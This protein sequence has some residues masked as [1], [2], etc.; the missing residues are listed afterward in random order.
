[1]PIKHLALLCASALALFTPATTAYRITGSGECE[2]P[3]GE[4]I[5]LSA[6][7][8]NDIIYFNNHCKE[9]MTVYYYD[10]R[11]D[12]K[13]EAFTVNG[14]TDGSDDTGGNAVYGLTAEAA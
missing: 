13:L 9:D 10:M 14:Y 12:V 11:G 3:E 7:Q 1:M 2:Y 8:G 5:N 4:T 6:T